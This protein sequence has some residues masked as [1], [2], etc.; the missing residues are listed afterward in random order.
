MDLLTFFFSTEPSQ[1]IATAVNLSISAVGLAS[2][3]EVWRAARLASRE[4]AVLNDFE[5]RFERAHKAA[6]DKP[7][8]TVLAHIAKNTP[9]G[10]L[11]SKRIGLLEAIDKA[12]DD[13][14][15]DALAAQGVAQLDRQVAFARWAANAVVLL[16]LGG[17]LIGL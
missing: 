4:A 7:A 12:G 5:E 6:G 3:A 16:G 17:T 8:R 15:G 14:D 11:L 1:Q 2:L 9:E 10:S 13:P